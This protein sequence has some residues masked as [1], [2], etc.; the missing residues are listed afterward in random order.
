MADDLKK[1]KYHEWHVR[2]SLRTTG[3]RSDCRPK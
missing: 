1:P 2:P 3:L